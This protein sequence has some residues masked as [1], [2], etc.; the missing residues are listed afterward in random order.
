MKTKIWIVLYILLARWLPRSYHFRPA[1]RIRG[2][3]GR[4]ILKNM[5]KNVNLEKGSNWG[6]RVSIGD[7]S[8]I[9]INSDVIGPVNIG[10]NVMMGPECAIYTTNHAHD[11]TDIPMILQ[12]Y[13]PEKPVVIE[14]DV[15]IGRRV[16]ILPGVTISKGCIVAAGAIV[17]KST[18]PYAIAGGNPAKIIKYRK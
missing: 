7:N 1:K 8:S 10:K 14:D 3:F 2:F 12:G 9:G 11:R 13:T 4:R 6:S 15:W 17:T 16:I 18:P 5:G